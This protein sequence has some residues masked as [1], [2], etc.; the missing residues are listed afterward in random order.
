MDKNTVIEI[1]HKF[2]EALEDSNIFVER[3]VLFGSYANGDW[4]EGSDIDVAVVSKSF[5]DKS[6]WERIE[7]LSQAIYKVFEPIEAVAFSPDE[8]ENSDRIIVQI[9]RE[10]IPL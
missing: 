6:Y 2:K 1:L 8:W 10:G 3:L 9:A 5:E 4:H 7:I